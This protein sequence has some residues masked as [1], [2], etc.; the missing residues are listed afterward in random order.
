MMP[1]LVLGR[2]WDAKDENGNSR[3]QRAR[4]ARGILLARSEGE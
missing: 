2:I 4:G 1:E 3:N